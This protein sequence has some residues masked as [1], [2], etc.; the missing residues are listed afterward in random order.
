MALTNSSMLT[1]LQKQLA[2]VYLL[3]WI[4]TG[5][6]DLPPGEKASFPELS[7]PGIIVP[8]SDSSLILHLF[9]RKKKNTYSIKAL[10]QHLILVIFTF[11]VLLQHPMLAQHLP[12]MQPDYTGYALPACF[13]NCSSS[14]GHTSW[15]N[16]YQAERQSANWEWCELSKPQSSPP[17]I[18]PNPSQTFSP[19]VDQAFKHMSLQGWGSSHSKHHSKA[20][21]V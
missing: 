20:S 17:D 13:F 19:T 8:H 4:S 18:P 5:N 14:W 12:H 16:I 10:P 15:G 2:F 6:P 3:L 7:L 1:T 11:C 9:K 21:A